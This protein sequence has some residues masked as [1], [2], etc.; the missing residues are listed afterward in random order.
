[1]NIHKIIVTV[2]CYILLSFQPVFAAIISASTT[3]ISG[4]IW[5][6]RYTIT[7]N[8]PIAIKWFT[9]Y[10]QFDLYEN[11][12]YIPT[13]EIGAEWDIFSAEPVLGSDGFVDAF[14]YGDGIAVGQSLT[15]F[16]VRYNF[17]GDDLPGSQ[18]FE[19][20]DPDVTAPLP[21][22]LGEVDIT[23]IPEPNILLLFGIGFIAIVT[24][25]KYTGQ[26]PKLR[27]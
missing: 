12:E 26:L 15:N 13:P 18:S 1:M 11:F 4:N 16:V 8:T 3:N 9:I 6:S 19:V 7:N 2:F 14:S 22:D 5:E 10:F 24:T 23:V 25:R 20:Y 17:L 27:V 21:I